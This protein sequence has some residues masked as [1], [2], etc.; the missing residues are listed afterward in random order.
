MYDLIIIG[1]GAAG[2]TASI[3]AS[4]YKLSH[5]VIGEIIGGQLN[6]APE[7]FNYPGFTSISGKTLIENMVSQVKSWGGEILVDSVTNIAKNNAQFD[8]TTK[9]QK[10]ISSKVILLAT[11]NEKRRPN[12]TTRL[13]ISSLKFETNDKDFIKVNYNLQTSLS[14]IF[15]AGDILGDEYGLEQLSTAVGTAARAVGSIY[16]FLKNIPAPIVWGKAEIRRV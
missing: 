8:V 11:G 9:S 7:L 15:A 13:L 6:L 2:L 14:G 5:T 12:E 10:V 4:C 3:Y 1:A 16:Q